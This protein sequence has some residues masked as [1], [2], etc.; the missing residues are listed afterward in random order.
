MPYIDH[1]SL[2]RRGFRTGL[3]LLVMMVVLLS[4]SDPG[5]A[6]EKKKQTYL[7]RLSGAIND[8]YAEAL[9]RKMSA[10]EE[11]GADRIILELDTPG[12]TV[13]A[14]QKLGDFIFAEMTPRIVAYINAKAY[15]GGTM[16]ALACDAIY[17]DDKVGMMGDVAPITGGGKMVGEKFQA[18][19][20]KTMTNYAEHN[21]YP[22]ALVE[23]MVTTSIEV[24]RIH[25]EG[26]PQ[27]KHHFV[28]KDVLETW[29]EEKKKKIT[30]KELIVPEGEL[31][32]MHPKE[33]VEYGFAKKAVSSRLAL[34]DAL[35]LDPGEVTRLYLSTSERIIVYLD[36]FS[37]LL[38]MGGLLLLF[39]EMNN[40]GFGLPGILGAS[41][42]VVFFIV[43]VSLNYAGMF[44]LILFGAGVV[45]LFIELFIIPGF[46]FVGAGGIF[47]LFVSILLMLQQFSWPTSPSEYKAF[48]I[49][50]LQ[51]V[52]IFLG[53]CVGLLTIARY[54]GSIPWLK[55]LIRTE[56]M[57]SATLDTDET[58][59]HHNSDMLGKTGR[60]ITVLRPAGKARIEGSPEQVVAQGAYIPEGARIEVI[61][62]RG[63]RLVVE[64]VDE[65]SQSSSEEKATT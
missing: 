64:P 58:P 48:E 11:Q 36:M 25:L 12:G 28:R 15:S 46:G 33:A 8:A 41:C 51:V 35:G 59:G 30:E 13:A 22:K 53:T 44:E 21:G 14:S 26:D 56:T 27:D 54:M 9:M 1:P 20:R 7:I 37:P 3:G 34:Y 61:A 42:I 40:P 50:L 17:I 49:N 32:T 65:D 18:P 62:S 16:V 6:G 19:I 55:R 47:L 43:K 38:M 24:Y 57:S 5:M 2:F 29:P 45:L 60:T 63:R 52:G 31:L 10:A 39:M 23:S 4:C